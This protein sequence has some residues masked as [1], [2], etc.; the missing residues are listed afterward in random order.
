MVTAIDKAR[1]PRVGPHTLHPHLRAI[2]SHVHHQLSCGVTPSTIGSVIVVVGNIVVPQ[3]SPIQQRIVLILVEIR[4]V[5]AVD[6]GRHLRG[7]VP[8]GERRGVHKPA[9]T[10]ILIGVIA[11]NQG[12]LKLIHIIIDPR[13]LLGHNLIV[14]GAMDSD[15]HPIVRGCEAVA[16]SKS[17][18]LQQVSARDVRRLRKREVLLHHIHTMG[19]HIHLITN[20][21]RA[22]VDAIELKIH[23]LGG[24]V[25]RHA[26]EITHIRSDGVAHHGLICRVGQQRPALGLG[27]TFSQ[28]FLL[29]L[30][31]DAIRLLAQAPRRVAS[32]A[33][34]QT[35]VLGHLIVL[36][37]IHHR[38][39]HVSFFARHGLVA[40]RIDIDAR[41]VG[42]THISLCT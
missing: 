41:Q 27:V 17:V 25:E 35:V 8:V 12:P 21:I 26:K 7:N 15:G 37:H 5:E 39:I 14:V 36:I 34:L 38:G 1:K 40:F 23:K 30:E 19:S 28:E 11:R 4:A 22:Q 32:S 13:R 10:F 33:Y 2:V 42:L 29:L 9:I 31:F 16:V 20:L 18:Y 3:R 24:W 6:I